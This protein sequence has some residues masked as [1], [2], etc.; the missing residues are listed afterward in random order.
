V[1]TIPNDFLKMPLLPRRASSA[2]ASGKMGFMGHHQIHERKMGDLQGFGAYRDDPAEAGSFFFMF[3]YLGVS[4]ECLMR[5][6]Y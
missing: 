5:L 4:N 6:F 2:L 3:S 1:F